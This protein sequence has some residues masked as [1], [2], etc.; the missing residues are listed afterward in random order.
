[1]IKRWLS[2]V[3]LALLMLVWAW[4][5]TGGAAGDFSYATSVT[6]RVDGAGL[7][8]VEEH[9]EITNN[10]P[11]LYLSKLQL[12]TPTNDVEGVN[13]SYDDGGD[14]PVSS[15]EQTSDR[16]G[17]YKYQRLTIAFPKQR[18]GQGKK[19]SFTLRYQTKDLVDSKGGSHTV[20]IP[21]I[22]PADGTDRYDV[23]VVVPENFG[24]AHFSGAKLASRGK[25]AGEQFF[26]FS[27]DEL[28]KNSLALAFGDIN[29]YKLNFNFPLKNDSPFTRTMT[30]ALPP[31]LNN[32]N[33]YVNSLSP[34]PQ[35][36]RVDADGNTLADYSVGGGQ[37]L[38]VKT[39]V[40][41][42]VK[43]RDYDL[44]KSGKKGDLP[45]DLVRRY[46]GQTQYWQANRDISSAAASVS[47]PKKLVA[48]NVRAM[49]QYVIDRLSYNNDKIAFNVRQGSAKAFSDP[50]NSVC[51][52]YADLLVAM[53]RSQGIPARMPVGYGYSGNLKQSS[54]VADSLHS[55][56]EAYVPGVG[57]MT[58]DPTWGEKF[59]DFGQSDLDHM[60]FSIWGS[61][62]DRPNAVMAGSSDQ[63]YQYEQ[64]E[65]SYIYT[66][67]PMPTGSRVE[68]TRYPILPWIA[69]DQISAIGQSQVVVNNAAVTIGNAQVGLG[70]LAPSQHAV[71]YQLHLGSDWLGAPNL[72]LLVAGNSIASGKAK[73]NYLGLGLLPVLVF[74]L[75]LLL[76]HYRKPPPELDR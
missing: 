66:A 58:L 32:Q 11:R 50:S 40:V 45:A 59:D 46:T 26:H 38:I 62:D 48:E 3:W 71:R 57:W 42:E 73:L 16:A 24:G 54:L 51:L 6:Y 15:S 1:M 14:L 35:G 17:G 76:R 25:T 8:N 53:L 60:A 37:S 65:L 31:N 9:Y 28:V 2:T 47:N 33:V 39:D 30:V 4:P 61:S 55:W 67:P 27:Q 29:R 49:Y 63:N 75:I 20:Y 69:I 41:G 70:D 22:E 64:T 19:W 43:H 10:T 72:K 23:T 56:V 7:T 5:S 18:Y 52:E 13:A 21:Q 74:G 12:S 34:A 36:T 44:S 68:A